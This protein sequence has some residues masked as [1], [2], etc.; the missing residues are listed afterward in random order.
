MNPQQFFLRLIPPRSTFPA[1]MSDHEKQLMKEHAEYMRGHFEL[2]RVLI[3]GPV[4]APGATFGMGVFNV[5]DEAEARRIMD[6]D[7]SVRG[8]LNRYELSPMRVAAAR[9]M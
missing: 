6:G 4:L 9:A 3:Y 8:G 7:P 2:G 5:A 1:D